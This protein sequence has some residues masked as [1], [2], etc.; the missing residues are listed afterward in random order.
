MSAVVIDRIADNCQR[1]RF[2]RNGPNVEWTFQGESQYRRGSGGNG[3][4]GNM[5]Q[6]CRHDVKV[7]V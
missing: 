5:E 1:V 4:N 6:Y 7:K 3:M 2:R